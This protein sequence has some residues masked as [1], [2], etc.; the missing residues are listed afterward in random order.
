MNGPPEAGALEPFIL[1]DWEMSN[2]VMKKV[3]RDWIVV[4]RKGKELGKR[5]TLVKEPYTQRM[6]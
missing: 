4:V 1:H 3:R 5:N 6:K 2:P